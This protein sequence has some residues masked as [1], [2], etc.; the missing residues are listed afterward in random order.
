MKVLAFEGKHKIADKFEEDTYEVKEQHIPNIPVFIVR[1]SKGIEKVLHINHLLLLETDVNIDKPIRVSRK[2]TSM[3][4]VPRKEVNI[5]EP[6][7]NKGA[8]VDATSAG[9][10]KF[11]RVHATTSG[12]DD[13]ESESGDIYVSRTY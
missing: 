13:S 2:R 12:N 8:P 10:S 6:N 7:N 11:P 4:R 3:S 5:E 1:S 9:N